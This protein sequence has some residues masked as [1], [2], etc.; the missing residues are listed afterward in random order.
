ME[1]PLGIGKTT[2]ML[3]LLRELS[4]NATSSNQGLPADAPADEAP[5]SVKI[6]GA[7]PELVDDTST[8][9]S[10]PREQSLG[11]LVVATIFFD[12]GD[13]NS[14]GAEKVLMRILHQLVQQ[15]PDGSAHASELYHKHQQVSP[16]A[17][18]VAETI[19][20]VI[21][22]KTRTCL[23]L[24]ALDE[25]QEGPLGTVLKQ[26]KRI[27]KETHI[28]ALMTMRTGFRS[29]R[30]TAQNTKVRKLPISRDAIKNYILARLSHLRDSDRERYPWSADDETCV[31]IT[32][33]ILESSA[34]M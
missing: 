8:T 22:S 23:F 11:R 7:L 14:H 17:D 28:G 3:G 24:D 19:I 15:L 12:S 13:P 27:Q 5:Q 21:G 29:F 4:R 33:T 9:R 32:E 1:G 20:K 18:D 25:C 2:M 6:E 10:E 31:S 30:G 16:I 26:I 34:N